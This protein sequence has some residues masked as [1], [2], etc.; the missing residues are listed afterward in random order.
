MRLCKVRLGSTGDSLF[1]SALLT[2]SHPPCP[3]SS[4]QCALYCLREYGEMV[5]YLSGKG[6]SSGSSP[7]AYAVT[8]QKMVPRLRDAMLDAINNRADAMVS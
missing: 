2:T 4:L 3:L 1:L 7:G 6:G 5:K 8:M